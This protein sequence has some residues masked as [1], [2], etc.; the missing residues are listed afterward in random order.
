[1]TSVLVLIIFPILAAA[2]LALEA[3]RQLGAHVFDP[4]HG[5][6]LLWQHLFWF[7]GHPEVYVIALP[8]FGMVSEIIPVFSRKPIFG[9]VGLVYATLA[10]AM[11][12]VAVWAH[13][14]FVTGAILPGVLLRHDVLDRGPDRGEVL[15]LDRHHVGGRMSFDTPMLFGSAS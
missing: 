5:G 15:Q 13:H 14:M 4:A 12:S 1:V 3:D 8:F 7:F 9:Y 11:L 10:I 6:V 2:L